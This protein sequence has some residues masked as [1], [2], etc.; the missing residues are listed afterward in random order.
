MEKID[1]LKDLENLEELKDLENKFEPFKEQI[2]E[3]VK[4]G[5]NIKGSLLAFVL[6]NR[7]KA[8]SIL[9]GMNE[10][11]DSM[12]KDTTDLKANVERTIWLES[13]KVCEPMIKMVEDMVRNTDNAVTT[14]LAKTIEISE[15]DSNDNRI[16][17]EVKEAQSRDYYLEKAQVLTDILDT[18]TVEEIETI[19]VDMELSSN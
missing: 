10:T 6:K 19:L 2:F 8:I 11:Y 15:K 17:L 13:C 3:L 12:N 14:M 9:Q 4:S 7:K 16:L 1:D 18:K 5:E